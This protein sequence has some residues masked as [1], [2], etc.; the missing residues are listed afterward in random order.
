[1][2]NF[3]SFLQNYIECLFKGKAFMKLNT[4]QP[5]KTAVA[6]SHLYI[7]KQ[8]KSEMLRVNSLFG[9]VWFVCIQHNTH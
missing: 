9:I 1:M 7:T 2:S 6:V 4:I 3:L 5:I 8:V